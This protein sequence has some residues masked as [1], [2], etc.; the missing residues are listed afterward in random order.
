MA[1]NPFVYTAD[2]RTYWDWKTRRSGPLAAP[3]GVEAVA[4]VASKFANSS[5]PDLQLT[6][7]STHPGFDGGTTY[8]DFLGLSDEVKIKS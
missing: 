8:K 3:V 4:F 5:Y 6:F 7:V 1:Y 2:P